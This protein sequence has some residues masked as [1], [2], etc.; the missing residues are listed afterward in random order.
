[1]NVKGEVRVNVTQLHN[2]ADELCYSQSAMSLIEVIP[3]KISIRSAA[4][5][6]TK[7]NRLK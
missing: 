7:P 4:N 3:T 2:P 1:M 5:L 6:A